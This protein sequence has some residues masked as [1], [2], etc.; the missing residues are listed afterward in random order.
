VRSG[1]M[2]GRRGT[3]L[4]AVLTAVLVASCGAGDG[5]T[6]GGA[7]DVARGEQLFDANCAVCHG[8]AATGTT[9][10]PPLVHEVYEPGHHSDEAFQVAVAR[11][12]PAHHWNF[13][14]MPAVPGLDRTDVA[15]ITAYVRVLQ[16][17]A[18]IG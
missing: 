11:G 9:I 8:P 1:R 2:G 3:V 12:V 18:G 14:P 6:V 16:R 10:G 15:D 13:G 4:A 7:V 5:P 17:E